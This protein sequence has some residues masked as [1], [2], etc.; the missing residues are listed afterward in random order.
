[1][2]HCLTI[3]S[4]SNHHHLES[5]FFLLNRFVLI[6]SGVFDICFDVSSYVSTD[7]MQTLFEMEKLGRTIRNHI[8]D[9]TLKFSKKSKQ[10]IHDIP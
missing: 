1:M 6:H 3:F 4:F 10:I 7:L 9:R 2:K 5:F 8:F